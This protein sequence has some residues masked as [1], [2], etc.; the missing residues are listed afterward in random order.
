MSKETPKSPASITQELE[1]ENKPN[2]EKTEAKQLVIDREKVCPMYLRMFCRNGGHHRLSDFAHDKQP[3]DDE[4]SVYT[5]RDAT[6]KEL[7]KL[8]QEIDITARR[9]DIK[10]T[11]R[12]V[13]QEVTTGRFNFKNV[14]TVRNGR[15]TA[16]DDL[17]LEQIRFIQGDFIDIA[18]IQETKRIQLN[19]DNRGGF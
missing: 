4:V 2:A 10:F 5:W 16:D 14:G 12:I 7:T 19:R 6:L 18:M 11:F 8:I 15:P 3:I 17:T 9:K 1:K 13:Y